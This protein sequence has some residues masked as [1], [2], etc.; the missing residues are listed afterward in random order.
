MNKITQK[1][2]PNDLK[3]CVMPK[4]QLIKFCLKHSSSSLENAAQKTK[5]L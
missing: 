1:L 3:E 5:N 2:R 4:F